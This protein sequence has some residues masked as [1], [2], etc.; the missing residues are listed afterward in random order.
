M[1]DL[2]YLFRQ[3][4]L[5]QALRPPLVDASTPVLTDL[6]Y[7]TN[8]RNLLIVVDNYLGA[9]MPQPQKTLLA[10]SVLSALREHPMHPYEMTRMMRI[11]GLDHAVK[12]RA[13]SLYT[14]VKRLRLEGLVE[15]LATVRDG[16]RPERTVYRLTRE[17][18]MTLLT[19]LHE[20]ISQPAVEHPTFAAATAFLPHLLPAEA[21]LL[22]RERVVNLHAKLALE[23]NIADTLDMRQ[24]P[25]LFTVH[26]NYTEHMTNAEIDW[27]QHLIDEIESG[28]LPWPDVIVKWHQSA[29][30]WPGETLKKKDE[31]DR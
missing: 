10:I 3:P 21:A 14:T 24:Y 28:D 6:Q 18:E 8:H 31:D 1:C 30:R 12:L 2:N 26:A 29:G 15:E 17:G 20:S 9:T 4:R 19:W 7:H 13:G 16:N 23:A 27:L 22:L 11:R 5:K 25:R